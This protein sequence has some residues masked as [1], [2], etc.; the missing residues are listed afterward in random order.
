M[1]GFISSGFCGRVGGGVAEGRRKVCGL[2]V[3]RYAEAGL[4]RSR[5]DLYDACESA[6]DDYVQS[7]MIVGIASE[8][9]AATFLDKISLMVEDEELFDLS[10]IF[11]S[12]AMEKHAKNLK[13]DVLPRAMSVEA[14]V[15][16]MHAAQFDPELNFVASKSRQSLLRPRILASTAKSLLLI[17]TENAEKEKLSGKISIE[18]SPFASEL[19]TK[20]VLSLPSLK[21]V[22]ATASYRKGR[23]SD[24]KEAM[25]KTSDGNLIVDLAMSSMKSISSPD[26]LAEEVSTS[27]YPLISS[28]Q[29]I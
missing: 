18:I 15:V 6:L 8:S 16:F 9:I 11:S 3:R 19:T 17:G 13:L 12:I 21:A 7:G 24:G 23:A 27:A 10:F 22:S 28:R 26:A 14:D 1:V 25:V 4:S 20:H 2:G 29:H 5:E